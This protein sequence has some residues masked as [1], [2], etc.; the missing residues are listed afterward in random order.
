MPPPSLTDL[1]PK[2]EQPL[3]V[4]WAPNGGNVEHMSS[5]TTSW[6][7]GPKQIWAMPTAKHVGGIYDQPKEYERRVVG[8]F[9]DHPPRRLDLKDRSPA[10]SDFRGAGLTTSRSERP[11]VE[12]ESPCDTTTVEGSCQA[13]P[14][15]LEH[16]TASSSEPDGELAAGSPDRAGERID[17]ARD[18]AADADTGHDRH[19]FELQVAVSRRVATATQSTRPEGEEKVLAPKRRPRID[20]DSQLRHDVVQGQEDACQ[21]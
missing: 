18:V 12:H 2:I 6:R 16:P 20:R 11:A 9:D 10:L 19:A 13:T 8:F 17:V 15:E 7:S 1:A 5:D 21:R 3:F 14:V 4:I